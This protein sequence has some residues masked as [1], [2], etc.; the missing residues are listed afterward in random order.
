MDKITIELSVEEQKTF[1][2][3]AKLYGMSLP[4]LFKKA[5]EE[6]IEDEIDMETV[7][8]YEEKLKN[9]TLET[10]SFDEVKEMLDL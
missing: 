7:K 8:K 10:Y 9:G 1:N 5:L 6:K 3:Y 4:T 2:K